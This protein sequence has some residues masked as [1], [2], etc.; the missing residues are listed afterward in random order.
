MNGNVLESTSVEKDLGVHVDKDLNF[1]FHVAG[2]VKKA[3]RMVGR[4]SRFLVNKDKDIMIPLF[5]SLV[6]PTL[7]YGN[8]VWGPHLRKNINMIENVQKRFTKRI[9]GMSDLTYEQRLKAL[10]LPSLEY[11]RM[12]GDMIEVYKIL[13]G[14]Y[15]SEYTSSLLQIN[16]SNTRGHPFKLTKNHVKT[17][18]SKNF[19]PNRVA[20][21]WNSLPKKTVLSGT[22]NS[23][24]TAMDHHWSHLQFI[25]NF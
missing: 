2:A 13:N 18:L 22:I 6:R 23:F 25:T 11:R 24:K 8:V 20:Y 3:N 15:N 5:K 9:H 4:I 21:N 14:S 12:R 19:F 1:D 17:N 16:H 10:K 7:E